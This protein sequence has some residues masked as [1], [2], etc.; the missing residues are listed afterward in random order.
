MHRHL[1]A[2][3]VVC[4]AAPLAACSA[5]WGFQDVSLDSPDAGSG[6]DGGGVDAHVGDGGGTDSGT[7]GSPPDGGADTGAET[8]AAPHHVS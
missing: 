1:V 6:D 4:A 7:D 5:I 3:L 2:A 8:V